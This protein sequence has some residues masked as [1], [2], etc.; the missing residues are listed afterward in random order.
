[1]R[2]V[3]M[4]SSSASAEC[5]RAILREEELEVVGVVTR[6]DRPAGRGKTLTPCPLAQFAECL[7]VQ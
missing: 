7:I 4:G 2:V 3:F 6:P 5:L 1:M